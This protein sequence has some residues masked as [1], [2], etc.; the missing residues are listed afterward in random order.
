MSFETVVS[1]VEFAV[2]VGGGAAA[3]TRAMTAAEH[4]AF[5]MPRWIE[6][7]RFLRAYGE[8][9]YIAGLLKWSRGAQAAV[10]HIAAQ[11]AAVATAAANA[12][13]VAAEGT[14]IAGAGTT[15][16]AVV[17]PVLALAAVGLALGAPYYQAREE[18]RKEG[19]ASG[20][21]KGFICGLLK[22]PMRNTI[23]LFWDNAV[24]KNPF[25]EALPT[26]RASSHNTGLLKG[27]LG[28][29][30]M[31]DSQKKQYLRALRTLTVVSSAG[32]SARSDDWM[33]Q[34]RAR[35]VQLGYV[36]DLAAAAVRHGIL[37]QG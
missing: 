29:L 6:R 18:A 12:S 28:G 27:R 8:Y 13:A 33:E 20:F 7:I 10:A 3:T 32:W 37:K 5:M 14:L 15:A 26:I 2:G 1:I 11:E 25:D 34:M 16:A 17:V 9:E 23:D 19:Y 24:Q 30:A 22:W 36:I 35:Q 4:L 31:S 21:S